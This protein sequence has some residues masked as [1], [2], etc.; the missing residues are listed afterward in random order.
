MST[1]IVNLKKIIT[2]VESFLAIINNRWKT[3]FL[4]QIFLHATVSVQ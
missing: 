4:R 2:S 3:H 1:P